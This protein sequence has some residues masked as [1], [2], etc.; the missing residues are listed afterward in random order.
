M[1]AFL[2][3]L[4]KERRRVTVC[5]SLCFSLSLSLSVFF[6]SVLLHPCI[7]YLHCVV[8]FSHISRFN[9]VCGI[10]VLRHRCPVTVVM[11]EVVVGLFSYR[12]HS[13]SSVQ[14]DTACGR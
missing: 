7:V 2:W 10:V 13:F 14:L 6:L 4:S 5:S 11:V 3:Q 1:R 12:A 9:S 8:S